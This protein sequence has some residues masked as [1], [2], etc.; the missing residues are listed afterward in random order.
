MVGSRAFLLLILRGLLGGIDL[1]IH[2]INLLL[3]RLEKLGLGF[4][5]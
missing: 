2:G 1:D 5:V 3:V 4:R